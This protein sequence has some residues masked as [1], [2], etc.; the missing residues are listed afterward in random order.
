MRKSK[1]FNP[2]LD[3][4]NKRNLKRGMNYDSWAVN[5]AKIQGDLMKF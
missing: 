2:E 4:T 1:G 5:P 3:F